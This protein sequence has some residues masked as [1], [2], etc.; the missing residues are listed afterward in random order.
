MTFADGTRISAAG[1]ETATGTVTVPAGG[2][3]F[4]CSIPG[5]ADA[6]MKGEVTVGGGMAGMHAAPAAGPRCSQLPTRRWRPRRRSPTRRP[7]LRTNATRRAGVLPGTVHDIDLPIIEK[8]MTVADGF[9]VHAWTFGGTVPG[10]TIRVHL[11]DTVNV[12]LTNKGR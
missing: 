3:A 8:D 2:L 11:G 10:P 9:V 7:G 6:G 4:I 5:H 1:G 12:H